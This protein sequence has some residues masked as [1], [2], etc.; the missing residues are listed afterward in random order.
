MDRAG[1]FDLALLGVQIHAGQPGY[2]SR[3]D[4]D[5]DGVACE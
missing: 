5:G 2:A 1:F 3:L 4:R